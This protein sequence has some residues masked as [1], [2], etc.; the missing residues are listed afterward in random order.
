MKASFPRPFFG[1]YHMLVVVI[2]FIAGLGIRV[3]DLTDLPLD[4]HPT[5]QLLSMLKARGMY[6]QGRGDVP[7]WQ[8][9]FAVQQWKS[10]AEI[11][12]EIIERLTAF[13]YR[14]TGEQVWVGRAYSILFW[15]IGG[16]FLYLLARDLVSEDGG[17]TAL[18]FYLFLPYAVFA[19]RSF[20]PDP[21]M[22]TFIIAFWWAVMRWST[23]PTSWAWAIATGLLGGLAILI[24]FSA[25]FFVLGG[26]LGAALSVLPFKDL[27]RRPQV[28]M[29]AALGVLP[30]A[31][32]FIYG[33]YIAGFLGQQFSGR[34]I[35]SLLASPA[36]YLNWLSTL[37]HV[38][39]LVFAL[40]L[41]GIFFFRQRGFILGLWG[42]Y[43]VYG[44][45]F[46]YHIWSHDYYNLPLLPIA[47]LSLSP[48]GAW[49]LSRLTES[50]TGSRW[51]RLLSTAVLALGLVSVLWDVRSTLKSTDYRPEAAMWAEIGQT[52]GQDARVVGLT[53]D[54]GSRLDFWG[55]L[56]A[57]QWPVAG[58]LAYH[59]DLRGAQADFEERFKN[60]ASK[61]DFFLV[62]LPDELKAQPMLK[63]RLATYPIF[64]EGDGY[65]IYDLR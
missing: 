45:Y 35:P 2:L 38:L 48:L 29:M 43:F 21:L 6:Y 65:V 1:A 44:F 41:L 25:V 34:F 64:A 33:V 3:Y 39:G 20:Q 22:V 46:D 30:G 40:A 27:I 56:D 52:L 32:Y 53:Q 60:L 7:E 24:K 63:E 23:H 18:A 42:A 37:N 9:Q 10:K 5:R 36:F 14:F 61:R 17:L 57:A 4:F 55:W 62:T 26:G 31:A 50:T 12:P 13:A 28:W 47:A 51:M 11:E 19:S 59:E 16:L 49:V 58:D 54:Y 15:L 8:R